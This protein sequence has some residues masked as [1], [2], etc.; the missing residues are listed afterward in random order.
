LE[1]ADF[2][3]FVKAVAEMQAVADKSD[4]FKEL[5]ATGEVEVKA[6]PVMTD[7]KKAVQ[8]QLATKKSK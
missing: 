5:G 6:D 4:L 7:V 3:N 8:A 2:D 1:D